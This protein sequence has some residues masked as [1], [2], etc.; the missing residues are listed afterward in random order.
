MSRIQTIDQYFSEFGPNMAAKAMSLLSPLH[1]P[2]RDPLP[3]FDGLHRQPYDAQAHAAAALIAAL[4]E[5]HS[6]LL[7][8]EMG[9]GK[10]L[11]GM[12]AV[13]LH[14]ARSRRQGGSNGQYRAL[15]LCPDHLVPKWREEIQITIEGSKVTTFDDSGGGCKQL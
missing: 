4:D 1:M 11:M 5:Q 6:A 2:G 10:S 12:A 7:A 9:S 3:D 14:A 13:H 15:V 8:A